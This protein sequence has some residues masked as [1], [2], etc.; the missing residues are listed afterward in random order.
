MSFESDE[1]QLLSGIRFGISTGAPISLSLV[2]AAYHRDRSNWPTVMSTTAIEEEVE[3]ITLPRPGHAD[4]VGTQKFGFDDIRPV[5]ERS[6]ARETAMRVA[7]SACARAFLRELGI[8]IGGHVIQLG[9]VGYSGWKEIRNIADPLAENSSA[10]A[11]SDAADQSEVRCLDDALSQKMKDEI[12]SVKK[13]GGSLG[14]IYEI[15][16]TGLPAG[17]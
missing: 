3:K 12:K 5:I 1:A 16:V 13:K 15:V 9:S 4:L 2:N 10:E 8:F 7:L 17:L 6:S 14:G 11:I